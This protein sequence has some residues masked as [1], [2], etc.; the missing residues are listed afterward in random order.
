MIRTQESG[1]SWTARLAAILL[2]VVVGLSVAS[3]TGGKVRAQSVA[4]HVPEGVSLL[5]WCGAPT[6]TG[7]LIDALPLNT[8]WLFDNG[9][10]AYESDSAALPGPLRNDIEIPSGVG[11]FASADEEFEFELDLA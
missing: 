7:E 5:G 1:R 3:G 6:S 11:F 10:N 2:A 8:I 4:V 9:T